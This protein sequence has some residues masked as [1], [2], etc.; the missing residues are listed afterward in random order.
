ML[1]HN[2]C[3][4]FEQSVPCEPYEYGMKD[5]IRAQSDGYAYAPAGPGLGLEVDW[6]AMDSA[7]I[8]SFIIE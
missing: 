3:S 5:V 1:A 6:E 4:Y 7:T 8:H 2:N